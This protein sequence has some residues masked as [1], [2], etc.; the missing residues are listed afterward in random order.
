MIRLNLAY[1]YQ[2]NQ[3]NLWVGRNI[4]GI[5]LTKRYANADE[6]YYDTS[7]LLVGISHQAVGVVNFHPFF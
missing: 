1:N 5:W 6:D 2:Y 3:L 4:A 7:F